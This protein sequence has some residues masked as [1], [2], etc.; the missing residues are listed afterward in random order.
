MWGLRSRL[1]AQINDPNLLAYLSGCYKRCEVSQSHPGGFDNTE[2]SQLE[3]GFFSRTATAKRQ[4]ELDDYLAACEGR[5]RSF[6]PA[7]SSSITA[8][9][10][11]SVRGR[12][13]A[14]CRH[15][16]VDELGVG[17]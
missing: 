5:E 7:E 10:G 6:L 12:R 2:T 17:D 1:D 9:P 15:L 3:T 13:R 16:V 11:A 4:Q 14:S 8:L